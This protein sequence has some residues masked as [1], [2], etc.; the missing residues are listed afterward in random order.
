M[1]ANIRGRVSAF[2][3][4]N[5]TMCNA[6]Q[7]SEYIITRLLLVPPQSSV[8]LEA[9]IV[10]ALTTYS[11]DIKILPSRDDEL[12]PS[13]LDLKMFYLNSTLNF[14]VPPVLVFQFEV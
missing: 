4:E 10:A 8:I 3:G 7:W 1:G 14:G 5:Y 2:L 6:M 13:K 12:L 11:L 9:C